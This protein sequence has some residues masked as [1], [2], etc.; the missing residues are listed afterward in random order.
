MGRAPGELDGAPTDV[1]RGGPFW[2][3]PAAE[4]RWFLDGHALLRRQFST[5]RIAHTFAEVPDP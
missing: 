5:Q 2:T 4:L 3:R 1:K